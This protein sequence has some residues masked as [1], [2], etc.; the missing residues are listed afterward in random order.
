MARKIITL[1]LPL[2]LWCS[3]IFVLSSIPNLRTELGFWDLIL[4]KAAHVTEFAVLFLLS[5]RAFEGFFSKISVAGLVS[6]AAIFSV[7]F[8]VSDE[9]HQSF[10]P[11]RSASA[12]DVGIDSCGVLIGLLVYHAWQRNH[13]R[14]SKI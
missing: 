4:R 14:G 13:L 2:V 3:L 8:A 10:V 1:W 12:Y 7:L 6:T 9:F 5:F 11:G